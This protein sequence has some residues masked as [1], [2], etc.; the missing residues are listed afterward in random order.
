MTEITNNSDQRARL[1]TLDGTL[2]PLR[3]DGEI[4]PA[5]YQR[6]LP[7]RD[8]EWWLYLVLAVLLG[9]CILVFGPLSVLYAF[10]EQELPVGLGLIAFWTLMLAGLW[11]LKRRVSSSDRATRYLKLY[12]DLLG[13]AQ[14]EFTI[15]GLLFHDGVHTIWFGPQLL[16]Q[17]GIRADGMRVQVDASTYR[18]LA[19]SARLFDSFNVDSAKR[20]K[21]HWQKLAE[22]LT[23][24]EHPHGLELW[25]Q[26]SQPP[27][28]AIL[29]SGTAEAP[30]PWRS[31][32]SRNKA[33]IE[34]GTLLFLAA[35]MIMEY[36]R[37]EPWMFWGCG[38]LGGYAIVTTL[39]SW[40]NYFGGAQRYSWYQSGW[41]SPLEFAICCG[42]CGARMPRSEIVHKTESPER[43]QLTM[44]SGQT[45]CI[46]RQMVVA[47]E[48]WQRLCA[49][50]FGP[51][52]S[53]TG[54]K[55]DAN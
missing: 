33:L 51:G 55:P 36:G 14:G 46:P 37:I 13:T 38:L 44:H 30:N 19:L 52:E 27:A 22:T 54:L 39:L 40:W 42:N 17:I 50:Q 2:E 47:D 6:M 4:E 31:P 15:D 28:E 48:Q 5:D 7:R 8:Q 41:I 26:L 18:Y 34:S 9:I 16:T 49:L 1:A 24:D 32:A 12:P 10:S 29:F 43:V 25:N 23:Q 3:F 11:F 53:A 35:F 45:Y 20:L 21:R